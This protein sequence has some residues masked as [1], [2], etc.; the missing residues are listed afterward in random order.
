MP[1]FLTR[2]NMARWLYVALFFAAGLTFATSL[3][4]NKMAAAAPKTVE[5]DRDALFREG[6]ALRERLVAAMKGTQEIEVGPW[7]A[8]VR[9]R[10]RQA[11]QK[12]RQLT[13]EFIGYDGRVS[14]F[15]EK[16][17]TMDQMQTPQGLQPINLNTRFLIAVYVSQLSTHRETVRSVLHDLNELVSS[18]RTQASTILAL[19]VSL[20]AV[21]IALFLG[22][23]NLMAR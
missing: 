20:A 11:E 18:R 13:E 19:I 23:L 9:T 7:E 15:M 16:L 6:S 3:G 2:Q 1:R 5:E 8:L 17:A 22:V 4:V 14:A 12:S 10:I 21:F